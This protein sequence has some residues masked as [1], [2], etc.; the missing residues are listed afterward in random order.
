L[1]MLRSFKGNRGLAVLGLIGSYNRDP[2]MQGQFTVN[3][4]S[5]SIS[6]Q[7]TAGYSAQLNWYLFEGWRTGKSV[8][9]LDYKSGN[10]NILSI[11]G[12]SDSQKCELRGILAA[13]LPEK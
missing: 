12:L 1:F 2:L 13:T 9:V 7:N 10:Y 6:I 3:V 4:S 5:T 8:I 11:G